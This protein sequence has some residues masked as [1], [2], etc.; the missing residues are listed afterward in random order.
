MSRITQR[1]VGSGVLRIGDKERVEDGFRVS[2]GRLTK[3]L[4]EI[5]RA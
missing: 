5:A 1:E 4:N 2:Y 3:K